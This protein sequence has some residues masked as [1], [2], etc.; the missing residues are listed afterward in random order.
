MHAHLDS[1]DEAPNAVELPTG[2]YQDMELTRAFFTSSS[3]IQQ[4]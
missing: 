2:K 1:N 4:E 3:I